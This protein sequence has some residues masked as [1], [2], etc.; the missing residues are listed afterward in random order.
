MKKLNL[1]Q[2]QVA[3]TATF[4]APAFSLWHDRAALI[5]QIYEA[6][7]AFGVTLSD[8]RYE[9]LDR[10]AS[11]ASLI[12]TTVELGN[13]RLKLDSLEWAIVDFVNEDLQEVSG[14]LKGIEDLL[15]SKQKGFEFKHHTINYFNHSKLSEGTRKSFLDSLST[16]PLQTVGKNLGT[17]VIY[18][19]QDDVL[20]AQSQLLITHSLI[21][22]DG[23]F[24]QYNF[25][26]ERPTVDY[27]ELVEVAINR[28]DRALAEID[29]EIEIEVESDES[30]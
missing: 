7:N 10:T 15:R 23:L 27:Q 28:L 18:H 9:T 17:G 3:Y 22:E 24:I 29:I 8:M 25:I 20:N 19:W 6:L 5:E 13:F 16:K 26:F 30:N 21:V 11:G 1:D 14:M 12:I 2:A 4:A